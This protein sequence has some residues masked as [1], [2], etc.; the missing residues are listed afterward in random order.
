VGLLSGLAITLSIAPLAAADPGGGGV[1]G[2]NFFG[3]YLFVASLVL[4]FLLGY[5][6]R[7]AIQKRSQRRRPT[8]KSASPPRRA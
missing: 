2:S 3:I 5:A 8:P 1:F 4:I 6:L 7:D